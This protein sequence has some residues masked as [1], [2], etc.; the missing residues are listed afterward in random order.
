MKYCTYCGAEVM[1]EAVVCPHC[2]CP[3][4]E[5]KS[6]A[7]DSKPV[8]DGH[9]LGVASIIAGIFVPLAGWICGGIGLSRAKKPTARI[10]K[11]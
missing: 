6:V 10:L 8:D 9:K 1:E 2:G 4:K 11:P 5:G 7:E 3:L